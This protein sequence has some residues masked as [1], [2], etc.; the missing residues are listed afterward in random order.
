VP[1]EGRRWG[2]ASR[3]VDEL[4]ALRKGAGNINREEL[5]EL[6]YEGHKY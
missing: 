4:Q 2:D 3:P 5:L 1:E 6:R